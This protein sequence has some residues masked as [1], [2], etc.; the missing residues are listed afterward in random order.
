MKY[1]T[2]RDYAIYLYRLFIGFTFFFPV[3]VGI[4]LWRLLKD[5]EYCQTWVVSDML[6]D[7]IDELW[8]G[9]DS[10]YLTK[11]AMYMEVKMSQENESD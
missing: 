5:Y 7:L 1:M 10:Q 4:I 3:C 2:I 8:F 9:E 6:E 11:R